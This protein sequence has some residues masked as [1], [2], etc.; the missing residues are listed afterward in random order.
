M[1]RISLRDARR[2]RKPPMTQVVLAARMGKPQNY[3]SRLENG[4]T[5]PAFA[6]VLTLAEILD[7]EPLRLTFPKL[8][9]DR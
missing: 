5:R 3:I 6:D 2:Q 7:V 8:V 1:K 4:L 9:E